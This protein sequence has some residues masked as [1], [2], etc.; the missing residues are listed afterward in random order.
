MRKLLVFVFT[1]ALLVALPTGSALA[2]PLPHEHL[3]TVP[4]TGTKVQVG[5]PRCALGAKLQGAFLNFHAN[6]HTG[7]PALVGGLTIEPRFC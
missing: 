5:P 1:L 2:Q 3:L 7:T 6:V 4:G